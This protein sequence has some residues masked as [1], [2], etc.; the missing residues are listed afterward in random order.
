MSDTLFQYIEKMQAG[1]PWGRVLDAG[2]GEHSLKWIQSLNSSGWTAVTIDTTRTTR[3]LPKWT[4]TMRDT[5]QIALGSW[6]DPEFLQGEQFDVVLADY[7]VGAIDAFTPY[8]QTQIFERL[9]PHTRSAFY[10]IGWEPFP[11]KPTQRSHQLVV[12]LAKTKDACRLLAG[13]RAYREY[14]A[15]WV[16]QQMQKAGYNVHETKHFTNIFR[17][18]YVNS[19]VQ[20]C[21]RSIQKIQDPKVSAAM[22][23]QVERIRDELLPFASASEGIRMGSDYVIT[24]HVEEPAEDAHTAPVA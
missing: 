24:A 15:T 6:T 14:P 9:R 23:S 7:L 12:E 11:D 20:G 2:T 16:E 13:E 19:Q 22:R 8:F 3:M 5:D 18:R 1:R 4:P 21:F 17:T 10:L